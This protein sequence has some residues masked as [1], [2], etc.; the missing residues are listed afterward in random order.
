MIRASFV[1]LL[2]PAIFVG[3]MVMSPGNAS[4]MD[5]KELMRRVDRQIS[6]VDEIVKVK[7]TLIN[8]AGRRHVRTA[9][10]YQKQKN[11]VTDMRIRPY[12]SIV[13]LQKPF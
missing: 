2:L 4:D 1:G 8:A 7:M 9:T 12:L 11:D 5:A 10:L 3:M 13:S 6:A